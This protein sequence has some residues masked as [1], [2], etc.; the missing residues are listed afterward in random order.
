M[1]E[2]NSQSENHSDSLADFA[3]RRK[4]LRQIVYNG[5]TNSE[6]ANAWLMLAKMSEDVRARFDSA[7][8]AAKAPELNYPIETT[9]AYYRHVLELNPANQEAR[10][11]YEK[12]KGISFEDT[13]LSRLKGVEYEPAAYLPVSPRIVDRPVEPLD[14][15]RETEFYWDHQPKSDRDF[16]ENMAKQ[17]KEPMSGNCRMAIGIPSY[18]E[19][20][21]IFRALET[22]TTQK[23]LKPEEIE[24]IVFENHPADKKRDNTN[25]E[26]ERFKRAYPQLKVHCVYYELPKIM[27]MGTIRKIVYDLILLRNMER[28]KKEPNKN[29]IIASNDADSYGMRKNTLRHIIDLFD[30]KKEVELIT[31]QWDLPEEAL[32]KF[33]TVHALIRFIKYCQIISERYKGKARKPSSGAC[34]Y[35]RVG[36]YAAIG[37]YDYGIKRGS[38]SELGT[39]I[40][41]YR[42]DGAVESMSSAYRLFT[43]PRRS[44]SKMVAGKHWVDQWQDIEWQNDKRTVGKSWKEFQE[45]TLTKFNKNRLEEEINAFLSNN[46]LPGINKHP[47]SPSS[48]LQIQIIDQV[49]KFMGMK[50][51]LK[52]GKVSIID[53]SRLERDLQAFREKALSREVRKDAA[54]SDAKTNDYHLDSGQEITLEYNPEKPLYILLPNGRKFRIVDPSRIESLKNLINVNDNLAII[55]FK[56][57]YKTNGKRGYRVIKDLETVNLGRKEDSVTFDFGPEISD[58]HV[59]I[60]RRGNILTIKDMNSKNGTIVKI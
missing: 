18:M 3:L 25:Q 7:E 42:R 57:V 24:I 50:A 59:Q 33:P 1:K 32:V 21:N 37:G 60:T 8:T 12:L 9:I 35:F 30:K 19:G 22:Y 20:S 48:K 43:D 10:K 6:K 29:L 4:K 36:T 44:L 45:D 55:D 27:P 38:D 31:G 46:V 26:I 13:V 53:T 39:R 54:F 52:N 16:I 40:F 5:S 15:S 56:V 49:M 47:N 51:E 34:S 2:G 11:A 14:E 23:G 17:I 41:Y 28:T 58:N